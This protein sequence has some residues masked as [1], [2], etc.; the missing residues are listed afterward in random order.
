MTVI[1]LIA[2]ILSAAWMY[3]TGS[4]LIAILNSFVA[5]SLLVAALQVRG[6]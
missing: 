5:G 1:F 2:N 4:H 3:E 6:L